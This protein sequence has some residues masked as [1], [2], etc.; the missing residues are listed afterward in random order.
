MADGRK[1]PICVIKI[2]RDEM[3]HPWEASYTFPTNLTS[4]GFPLM[5]DVQGQEHVAS[6][7][8]L[9]SDGHRTYALTNRHVAGE[10][11]TPIYS[12]IGNNRIQIG[13]A[14]KHILTR[15]AFSDVYQGWPAKNVYIDL[16]AALIDIDDVN[17][18]TTQIYGVGRSASSPTS[19]L[20][21][22][23]YV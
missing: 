5:V 6:V 11:G 18:W 12:L 15:K 21:T 2:D 13:R 20:I 7:G 8:C 10:P 16:D 23:R 19:P 14:T 1:A 22:S 17:R 3:G 9:V 4:G